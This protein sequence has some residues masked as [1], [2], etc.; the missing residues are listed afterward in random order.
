[1]AAI[2]PLLLAAI[3]GCGGSGEHG[4]TTGGGPMIGPSGAMGPS[5]MMG[6]SG[7]PAPGSSPAPAT[8]PATSGPSGGAGAAAGRAL[9]VSAGCGSCHT[10]AD[11]GTSGRIG[12]DL[13]QAHP[14]YQLALRRITDGGDGMPSFD[15]TLTQAQIRTLGHYL[16]DTAR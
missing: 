6:G 4:T 8:T 1:V 13:E 10:L 3:A 7:G 2:A 15:R 9:F 11:A 14:D 5:G 16:V 12:P